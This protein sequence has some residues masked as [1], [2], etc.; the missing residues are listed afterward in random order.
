MRLGRFGGDSRRRA[1]WWRAVGGLPESSPADAPSAGGTG[2]ELAGDPQCSA[3]PGEAVLACGGGDEQGDRRWG[4]C[5]GAG[6]GACLRRGWVHARRRTFSR[7]GVDWLGDAMTVADAKGEWR[8]VVAYDTE[9]LARPV[10][11]R[12]RVGRAGPVAAGHRMEMG[13]GELVGGEASMAAKKG[14]GGA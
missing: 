6:A 14:N 9:A 11:A 5:R 7:D 13:R 3:Q 4:R 1:E 10:L 2:S 12:G 8:H